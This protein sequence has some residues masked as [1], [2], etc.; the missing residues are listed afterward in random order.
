MTDKGNDISDK[1]EMVYESDEK[2]EYGTPKI[3]T[4]DQLQVDLQTGTLPDEPPPP[5]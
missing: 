2:C 4:K 3:L 1:S 5:L